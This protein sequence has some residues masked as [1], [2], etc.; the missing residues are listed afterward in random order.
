MATQTPKYV[1]L[2]SAV[3]D[4]QHGQVVSFLDGIDV[5]RLLALG[6]I[7][8]ATDE[9]AR[10]ADASGGALVE[11]SLASQMAYAAQHD[12]K[13]P[14][15]RKQQTPISIQTAP[16]VP[17]PDVPPPDVSFP[18]DDEP[19]AEAPEATESAPLASVD[20]VLVPA[21][22]APAPEGAGCVP[23]SE[24]ADEQPAAAPV[25]GAPTAEG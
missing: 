24:T 17:G 23:S 9:E 3:G 1:V 10:S 4:A 6:A 12:G 22:A 13:L 2:H 8:P 21:D 25:E 16:L 20:G 18:R 7:R 14:V 19:A 5:E 11:Y 15:L